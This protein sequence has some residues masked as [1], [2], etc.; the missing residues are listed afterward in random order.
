MNG[1]L[2]VHVAI[3]LAAIVAG[4]VVVRGLWTGHRLEGWTA[5]FLATTAATCISGFP[6]PADRVLPSHI[7]GVLTLIAVAIAMAGRYHHRL[8]G[9]WRGAYIAGALV[10]LYFNV[11]VGVV[12]AFLAIP[13]LQ[14][15]APTQAEW[16][17]LITQ[18][19]LLAVFVALGRGALARFHPRVVA[20]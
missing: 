20:G 19:A 5:A 1:L 18:V 17:F 16:P 9:A 13:V 15:L 6:L 10:A 7:V 14:A 11:F 4:F 2:A 12:Q 3:S 8:A